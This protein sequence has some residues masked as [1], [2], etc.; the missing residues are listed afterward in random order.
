V[1]GEHQNPNEYRRYRQILTTAYLAIVGLGALWLAASVAYALVLYRPHVALRGPVLSA[2]NPNPAE[3][4][5]CL[6]DTRELLAALDHK[7]TALLSAPLL[8]H[9]P[10]QV[11]A[12]WE[13]FSVEWRASWD[14]VDLRCRFGELFETRMGTAYDRMARVH[15]DLPAMR[16]KYQSL[17]VRFGD[18]Q[19]EQLAEMVAELDKSHR[20]LAPPAGAQD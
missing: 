12:Q 15:G 20:A 16:L 9:S 19:A 6:D 7:M 5:R 3:L 14:E 11:D 4:R 8:G 17:L 2:K 18:E 10:K 13:H 1:S